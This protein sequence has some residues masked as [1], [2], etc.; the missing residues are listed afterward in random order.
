LV[1]DGSDH[2]TL[3]VPI[4]FG[5]EVNSG[6]KLGSNLIGRDLEVLM[7]GLGHQISS[8]E[9][10]RSQIREL[11]HSKG[12]RSGLLVVGLV[13]L[14]VGLEDIKTILELVRSVGFLVCVLKFRE[15][16]ADIIGGQRKDN[17]EHENQQ[18]GLHDWVV[19]RK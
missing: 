8:A 16:A 9:L 11:S 3:G 19:E 5:G 10:L 2:T 7:E 14:K 13:S 12:V 6:R 4:E 17:T 1:V 15:F 18:E